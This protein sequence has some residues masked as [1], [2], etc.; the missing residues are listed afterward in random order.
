[1]YVRILDLGRDQWC[2]LVSFYAPSQTTPR[3]RRLRRYKPRE[4]RFLA[5]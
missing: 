3:E 2:A 4:P 1:M 5:V